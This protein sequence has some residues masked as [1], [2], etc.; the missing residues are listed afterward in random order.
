MSTLTISVADY[1]QDVGL[2]IPPQTHLAAG[3]AKSI[4]KTM[5]LSQTKSDP[6][7]IPFSKKSRGF[8]SD[9]SSSYNSAE[10]TGS[11]LL[12]SAPSLGSSLSSMTQLPA[13]KD[14][15]FT[16]KLKIH[17]SCNTSFLDFD[18]SDPS[19]SS[20]SSFSVSAPA[21]GF[22]LSGMTNSAAA[23]GK[24]IS[25][26]SA[27]F[28][29][30]GAKSSLPLTKPSKAK[31]QNDISSVT[32]NDVKSHSSVAQK[33]YVCV[34]EVKQAIQYAGP[35]WNLPHLEGP[36][37][38]NAIAL[39]GSTTPKPVSKPVAKVKSKA[40]AS[41]IDLGLHK[42]SYAVADAT[43]KI[44][45]LPA[46][47]VSSG[48]A[49]TTEPPLRKLK[50]SLKVSTLTKL[51]STSNISPKSVRFASRLANVKTF[52]GRDSPSTVSLQNSPSGSPTYSFAAH[53]YFSVH[54]NFTDLGFSDEEDIS[55]D[56]DLDVD[57]EQNKEKHY[58]ITR[59]NFVAPK[60]IYDKRDHPVYL[61]LANLSADK[62][63]MVLLIMCQNLAFEKKLSVKLTL[64]NWNSVLIFNNYTYMK[65]FTSVDYDQFQVVIPFSHFASSISP[66][67]CIR[68]EVNNA[69][70]WDNNNMKNYAFSLNA[71]QEKTDGV[72]TFFKS[73][74]ADQHF[75]SVK[76]FS[77]NFSTNFSQFS[78]S[79]SE[80]KGNPQF[81]NN[82]HS[83]VSQAKSSATTSSSS[84]IT[85][86]SRGFIGSEGGN[87]SAATITL[88]GYTGTGT[89]TSS[90][91]KELVNKLMV[92]K[93]GKERSIPIIP[94]AGSVNSKRPGL[95]HAHSLPSIPSTPSTVPGPRFSQAYLSK[96]SETQS[97]TLASAESSVKP[98]SLV[99]A[100]S[101]NTLGNSDV[102][103]SVSSS[104]FSNTKFNSSSYAALLANYCFN[105]ADSGIG[106]CPMESLAG[107]RASSSSSVNSDFMGPSLASFHSLSDSFHV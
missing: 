70:Y 93:L 40:P 49:Y 37:L 102:P 41:F 56:S 50:L 59:S 48:S 73:S 45:G 51:Y 69:T 77:A 99:A 34:D 71:V 8:L 91:Y 33:D 14:D 80:T 54:R 83:V 11:P 85:G 9:F 104:D 52:D 79:K 21:T 81:T 78:T 100:P 89:G 5:A 87:S 4:P 13:I 75:S 107:L 88:G 55:S 25:A 64:N 92:A 28:K 47:I 57:Q 2:A 97:A 19:S 22:V 106:S 105:G 62:K 46:D 23:R 32:K 38:V 27:T 17:A 94:T 36:K 43:T 60:S 1:F 58:K 65:L 10:I 82:G 66:Q 26:K 67:F 29:S 76:N 6:L 84:T 68:Y 35:A 74:K 61:Q 12:R 7:L 95:I 15:I 31:D 20:S 39:K 30:Q 24:E 96:R 3:S 44:P 53:D 86:P 72:N 98:A 90:N 16:G 18:N 42:T 101:F 63:L 103:R